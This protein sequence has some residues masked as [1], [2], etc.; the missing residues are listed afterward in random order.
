MGPKFCLF[1]KVSAHCF[2]DPWRDWVLHD[3]IMQN[4]LQMGFDP[5]WVANLMQNKYVLTGTAYLSAPEL[6]SDLLQ[7][8]WEESSRAEERRG[9]PDSHTCLLGGGLTSYPLHLEHCC[10]LR[11]CLLSS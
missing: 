2:T 6:I 8:D 9:T 11:V 4:V 10:V 7:S 3:L 5:M 1:G